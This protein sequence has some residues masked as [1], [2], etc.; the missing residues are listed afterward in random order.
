[1]YANKQKRQ[2]NTIIVSN[3]FRTFPFYFVAFCLI[4]LLA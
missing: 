4:L 1:M 3:I 2:N